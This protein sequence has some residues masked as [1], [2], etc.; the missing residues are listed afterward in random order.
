MMRLV[1]VVALAS[2]G[3]SPN[4]GTAD[5]SRDPDADSHL[6]DAKEFH[7]AH[8]F[9]DA[10]VFMDAMTPPAFDP[11]LCPAD[12]SNSTVTASPNT[13]YKIIGD[14]HTFAMHNADCNDDHAGWTH[15]L[16]IDSLDE[17]QQLRS[18]VGQP[19]YVGAVQPHDSAGADVGWIALTG[20]AI[21]PMFWQHDQ[22][23]DNDFT[24]VENNDQN[25]AAVDDSSGLLND[26]SGAFQYEA[27]CECDGLP[28]SAA[29]A[30]AIAGN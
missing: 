25:F 19:Y 26:V 20:A 3:F 7:D 5:A 12:Y 1:L 27:V 21:D 2:C 24:P 28:V 13:R 8:G 22:P 4:Q 17:A 10:H 9:E 29:A 16:V 23:N 14:M 11:A 30:A 15:L 6:I 18:H